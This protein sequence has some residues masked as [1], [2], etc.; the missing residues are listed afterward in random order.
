MEALQGEA[1]FRD[2]LLADPRVNE[3]LGRGEIEVLLDP[4]R[5]PGLASQIARDVVSLSRR[6]RARETP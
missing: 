2:V 6:E 5:Y 4:E 1:S 3:H